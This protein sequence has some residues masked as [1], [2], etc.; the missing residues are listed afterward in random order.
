MESESTTT[1][2]KITLFEPVNKTIVDI[3]LKAKANFPEGQYAIFRKWVKYAKSGKIETEYSDTGYGR[4]AFRVVSNDQKPFKV[5]IGLMWEKSRSALSYGILRDFDIENCHPCILEQ[6]M[7]AKNLETRFL[8]E[9]NQNRALFFDQFGKQLKYTVLS[10]INGATFESPDSSNPFWKSLYDELNTNMMLLIGDKIDQSL[11]GAVKYK[12]I[13][14]QK[15]I[16]AQDLEKKILLQIYD[17]CKNNQIEV[18][19]LIYDGL[20]IYQSSVYDSLC[21]DVEQYILD[22]TGF[23]IKFVE[24]PISYSPEEWID[25]NIITDDID[26]AKKLRLLFGGRLEKVNNQLCLQIGNKWSFNESDVKIEIMEAGFEKL[27]SKGEPKPYSA[28]V[29][30]CNKL[31][32]TLTDLIPNNDQFLNE[33][34]YQTLNKVFYKNG[35]YDLKKGK[36]IDDITLPTIIRI[37]R[38]YKDYQYDWEHPHVVEFKNRILNIFGNDDETYFTL[39][40]ISRAIGGNILDKLFYIITGSRN[41]GKGVLFKILQKTFQQ[42]VTNIPPVVAKT[43]TNDNAK[44][45]SWILSAKCHISRIAI[46]NEL[47]TDSK[48]KPKFDGNALKIFC[49]GGDAIVARQNYTNEVQVVNN[50]TVFM[51]M[52]VIPSADPPDSMKTCRIIPLPYS[53]EEVVNPHLQGSKKSDCHLKEWITNTPWIESVFE[54]MVFNAFA[55][56][57]NTNI[58]TACIEYN[59][60]VI[61]DEIRDEA[62]L[63]DRFLMVKPTGH[64]RCRDVHDLFQKHLGLS[65]QKAGLWMRNQGYESKKIKSEN[66]Q[67]YIGIQLKPVEG[68]L[69]FDE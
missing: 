54:W 13:K 4:L 57:V 39:N 38:D 3:L 12:H 37:D 27:N 59:D 46:S 32:K 15:A 50:C 30:G 18:A 10:W 53:F 11:K 28:N 29:D 60:A 9:Y 5:G 23:K 66:T 20:L 63:F 56:D 51:A 44:A 26:G 14:S 64:V 62:C 61:G 65:N 31:F 55:Y 2:Q 6:V 21:N 19:S 34:N 8:S 40:A 16:F 49:S 58:P 45:N 35:Y 24:K 52:N 43:G 33:L 47:S 67:C 36:F 42:Y 68:E 7:T 22:K 69:C 25:D 48:S 17:F 1:Q 41:S